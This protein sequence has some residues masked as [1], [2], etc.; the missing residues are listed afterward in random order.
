MIYIGA[1]KWNRHGIEYNSTHQ[2]GVRS[3]FSLSVSYYSG[4]SLGRNS[5]LAS[6]FE[7]PFQPFPGEGSFGY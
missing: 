7:A 6:G 3:I 5:I 2:F 1:M 4:R